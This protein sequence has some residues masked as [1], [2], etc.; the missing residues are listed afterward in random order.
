MAHLWVEGMGTWSI[1]PL[2]SGG[3]ALV[4]GD[5]TPR[6]A[7][8]ELAAA[9]IAITRAQGDGRVQWVLVALSHA[10]RHVRVNGE[11]L[12]LD[13]RVLIDR[14]EVA[15]GGATCFFSTDTLPV[16]TPFDGVEPVMCP[17]CK[18]AIHPQEHSVQCPGCRTHY[19]QHDALPCWLYAP[20]CALCGRATPLDQP[21]P[22]TPAEL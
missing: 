19:H 17:R 21:Y 8:H 4:G 1:V 3:A 22:W 20:A 6:G 12:R 13:V 11:P 2:A 18:T 15:V 10:R 9:G 7:D 5:W 16:V 14:D